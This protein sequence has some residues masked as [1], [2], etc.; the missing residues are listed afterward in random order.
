[1]RFVPLGLFV[2]SLLPGSALAQNMGILGC[3]WDDHHERWQLKT[4]PKPGSLASADAVAV[5]DVL[6]WAVPLGHH[7][8]ENTAVVPK[9]KHLFTLTGFVRKIKLSDDDCDLHLEL[10]ASGETNAPRVIVEIPPTRLSLQKIVA[11]MFNLSATARSHT[12]NGAK[13]LAVV[14]TGFGFVDLSHQCHNAPTAGCQHGG[15]QVKTLW[16]LHPI[17][18]LK[19]AH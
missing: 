14:V 13:A 11:A 19:W 18:G 1:M 6:A 4:R 2:L 3:T 17:F 9:E 10:A 7:D 15:S 8:T 5:P 12:Y 16:E